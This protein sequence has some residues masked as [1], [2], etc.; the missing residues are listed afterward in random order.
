VARPGATIRYTVDGSEPG[1]GSSLYGG[2]IVIE[3]ETTVKARAFWP[4][5]VSSLVE[6]RTFKPAVPLAA[7]AKAPAGR[8][9]AFEYFEGRFEEL[10]DFSALKAAR[11]GTCVR[12]DI[13]AANDKDDFALR[14]RGFV[15][16]PET[17][18]VVFY[19]NS[20]DGTKLSVAGKEI[21]VNDGVHGMTEEKAEI[22]LEAG[23]HPFELLYFQGRGGL[24]LELSWQGP[25]IKKG[26]VPA[27][28]FGR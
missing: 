18:V 6:S 10:P 28:A 7:A 26:P 24:G 19:V 14:F 22:A 21:V 17:G 16:I 13:S 23:W 5:G 1:P 11:T 15:R 4:G 3:G 2:P 9:L 8:G 20:D 12:P 25:G 27:G